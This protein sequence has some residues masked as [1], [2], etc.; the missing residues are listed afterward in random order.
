[1]KE[2]LLGIINHYGIDNQQ[3]KL[4]EEVFEL[5]EIITKVELLKYL[6]KLSEEQD[7]APIWKIE[8]YYKYIEEEMADVHVLLSQIYYYYG[9]DN[10]KITR[11]MEE[12]VNRQNERIMKEEEK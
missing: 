12:K 10:Q 7:E 8:E 1:M 11:I 2:K 9:L 5:Q 6:N 4:Q 3:R